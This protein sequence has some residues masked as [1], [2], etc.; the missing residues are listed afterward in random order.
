MLFIRNLIM[1]ATVFAMLLAVVP[2]N[3]Q[4]DTKT[5]TVTES[6]INALFQARQSARDLS[7]DLH[8]S[9]IEFQIAGFGNQEIDLTL[10]LVVLPIVVDYRLD[11]MLAD[12]Y[13]SRPNG[14][15]DFE[16]SDNV[17][18]Q[19]QSWYDA[20]SPYLDFY[21][22]I[23]VELDT[24]GALESVVVTDDEF[25]TT[26]SHQVD[27]PRDAASGMASGKRSI[28]EEQFNDVLA[29]IANRNENLESL[30]V[31][32]QDGQLVFTGSSIVDGAD[33][34]LWRLVVMPDPAFQVP[35]STD[36]YLKIPDIDGEFQTGGTGSDDTPPEALKTRMTNMVQRFLQLQRLENLDEPFTLNISDDV[37]IIGPGCEPQ[38]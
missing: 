34:T 8:D 24:P 5:I 7:V 3:A 10:H 29:V 6:D 13:L 17:M 27:S 4:D 36:C 18:Q 23:A 26:W 1:A 14:E 9:E 22:I 15:L 33:Y 2:V 35:G 11:F 37:V 21:Q 25:I 19:I 31:D 20:S 12:V 38:S 32:I 28:T 30:T 16:L